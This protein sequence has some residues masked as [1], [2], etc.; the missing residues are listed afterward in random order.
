MSIAYADRQ[1]S[2]R[3]IAA[4]LRQQKL[5]AK[6]RAAWELAHRKADCKHRLQEEKEAR[7]QAIK[8]ESLAKQQQKAVDTA[9]RYALFIYEQL[10]QDAL[11]N[12]RRVV[13]KRLAKIAKKLRSRLRAALYAQ[14]ALKSDLSINLL[15][16]SVAKFKLH[17]EQQF[18]DGMSWDNHGILWQIDHI[19]PCCAFN[20]SK[21]TEQRKC[22]NYKNTQPLLTHENQS[23]GGRWAS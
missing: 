1:P 21:S 11:R 8:L 23:K 6:Q 4:Q 7:K 12:R 20:L 2:A 18:R 9:N 19:K 17:I 13:R 5:E 16:C 3:F 10:Q 14:Q 15:G 22:F